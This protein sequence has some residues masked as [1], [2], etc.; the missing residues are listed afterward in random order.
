MILPGGA[1]AASPGPVAPFVPY[2]PNGSATQNG[3]PGPDTLTAGL[4]TTQFFSG[5]GDD[6]LT[7]SPGGDFFLAGRD[8]DW[9]TT[10]DGWDGVDLLAIDPVQP[11]IVTDFDPTQ[12]F[13]A[14]DELSPYDHTELLATVTSVTDG[15]SGRRRR[16]QLRP[17]LDVHVP[18]GRDGSFPGPRRSPAGR[19]GD[20]GLA[21][22]QR[23]RARL[24]PLESAAGDPSW[25]RMAS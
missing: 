19:L 6:T 15:R 23:P 5:D 21:L 25:A 3:T 20:P 13:L 7:G 18:R 4:V 10:G 24:T 2:P 16:D 8:D 17:R 9:M 1:T 14:F 11:D 22:V 12:D